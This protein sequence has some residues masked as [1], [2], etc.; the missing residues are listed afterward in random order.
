MDRDS[1]NLLGEDGSQVG[2]I[3]G[4]AFWALSFQFESPR[5]G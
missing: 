1:G 3:S 2:E 4:T 5:N